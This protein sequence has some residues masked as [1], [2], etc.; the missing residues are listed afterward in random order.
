[1]NYENIY[2]SLMEYR[3][4]NKLSKSKGY[5]EG[6]HIKPKS[7]Y[8]ELEKDKTNII[9]LTAR[10]HYIA[11]KLLVQIYKNKYGIDS[12]QYRCMINAF[13]YLC[14]GKQYKQFI[15]SKTYEKLKIEFAQKVSITQS[16]CN[17]WNYG[18]HHK[19]ET[20]RKIGDANKGN[21]WSEERKIKYGRE[22]SGKNNPNYG[23]KWSVEQRK[24]ASERFKGKKLNL[25]GEQRKKASERMKGKNNPVYGKSSWL[26]CTPEQKA[27]RIAR[28]Q[29]SLGDRGKDT[30]KD[31]RWMY[32][33]ETNHCTLVLKDNIDT[34]LQKGYTF[35]RIF[36]NPWSKQNREKREL[37]KGDI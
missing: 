11:H 26:K 27:D 12:K 13:W 17:H 8:P 10:E 18:K 37:K 36:N 22:H 21:T 20:K 24:R 7:L 25:T 9:N 6:H 29:K 23:N 14:H 1:M 35:G 30:T 4:Q 3:R 15:S 33:I 34:Y 16:G 2:N 5:C 31:S 28:W 19:E 32:H